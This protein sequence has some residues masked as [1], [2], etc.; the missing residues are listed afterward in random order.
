M[1]LFESDFWVATFTGALTIATILLWL[2][3]RRLAKGAEAQG[4]DLRRSIEIADKTAAAAME[5]ARIAERALI[6][7]QRA[8][9]VVNVS[10][11][12]HVD[13]WSKLVAFAS[14]AAITCL[15]RL[16]VRACATTAGRDCR[17][18]TRSAP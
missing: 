3:T 16:P 12:I 2:S 11:N 10:K 4:R 13:V 18:R 6:G 9:L 8:N 1:P 17:P 15:T 5:Q 7:V 14:F